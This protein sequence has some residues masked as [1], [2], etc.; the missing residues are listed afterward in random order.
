LIL[1]ADTVIKNTLALKL[2]AASCEESWMPGISF[3]LIDIR[4]LTLRRGCGDCT[5]YGFST[6]YLLFILLFLARFADLSV[7]VQP[8]P[9]SNKEPNRGDG[10]KKSAN[11]YKTVR[12]G[13]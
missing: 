13:I 8:L 5:P 3:P 9:I 10:E 2:L 6:S 4:S 7:A 11:C 12:Y 1:V